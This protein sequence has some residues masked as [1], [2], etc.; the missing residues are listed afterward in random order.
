MNKQ[1]FLEAAL[2]YVSLLGWAVFPLLPRSKVPPKGSH[3]FL[4]ATTDPD[5]V[6][7]W[8]SATP[9]AN[10]GLAVGRSG[11]V[12]IDVDPR[13]GGN[14]TWQ[15][16]VGELGD[17]VADTVISLTGT[18]GRHFIY[19]QNGRRVKTDDGTLGPGVDTVGETGY[20]ILPPSIHPSGKPYAWAPGRSPFER[21]PSPVPAALSELLPEYTDQKAQGKSETRQAAATDAD[22]WL[23]WALKRVR[24]GTRNKT[25]FAL[26]CQLRDAGLAHGEAR[27]VLL[28][29]AARVANLGDHLYTEAEALASLGQAYGA[30]AR[31]RA[32]PTPKVAPEALGQNEVDL[33]AY[34]LTDSGN[35]EA[36]AALFGHLLRFAHVPPGPTGGSKGK[37]LL[38]SGHHWAPADMGQVEALAK[39]T[40]RRRQVAAIRI[41]DLDQRKAA[42]AWALGSESAYRRRAMVDLARSEP[43]IA[44]RFSDFDQD[45]W[46]LG[47]RNGVLDLRSGCLRPGRPSDLVTK[48][49]GYDFDPEAQCPRW[50]RFLAEVFDGDAQLV[51]FLRRAVGYSLTGDV[52]EQCLFLC[53]GR[54]CNGKSVFLS[55][56]RAVLG[57][58]AANTPFSTFEWDRNANTTNDL[59]ALAGARLVTASETS[60]ARRLN[61]ARVKAITGGDPVTCRFLFS[62][63]FTF[64]PTFKVWLAM[65]ALPK[66]TGTDDGIWRRIRLIPFKVSF[67]GRED[68]TLAATLRAELPG[69]LRWA[70]EGCLEWQSLGS[71]EPP[72]A[73]TN[74][75]DAFR[76]ESDLVGRFLDEEALMGEGM[77][78]RASELYAAFVAWAKRQGE[79]TMTGTA[80]GL[81]MRD[82][83]YEKTRQKT[84]VVYV[85][86]GLPALPVGHEPS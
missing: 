34:P 62:E 70:L 14:E 6:R 9:E 22:F 24:P 77:T 72:E 63:F 71:L 4:D 28:D 44:A 27:A 49:V 86:L 66:V 37:W 68:R 8:W 54:G 12:V 2:E 57:D 74:A 53:H 64:T 55:T 19:R 26:A 18:A 10:I 43:P 36:L 75:T 13:H 69:I 20:I 7:A 30:P 40:A 32:K 61:E 16:L 3:G 48:S 45:P 65:N 81:R 23:R 67:A 79:D 38:W 11:L 85:G 35:G 17:Q 21:Q 51:G 56:L 73:V 41:E 76:K 5:Q 80:F 39:E 59:A 15:K 78:V 50:E 42:V 47:C 1:A 83:G 60:E 84:G 29:Y 52:R 25:G 58:Y 33:N 46:L 82:L 31:E